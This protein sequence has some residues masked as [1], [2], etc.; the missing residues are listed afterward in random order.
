MYVIV[1][2]GLFVGSYDAN[3][4]AMCFQ[5][6]MIYF[7]TAVITVPITFRYFAVCR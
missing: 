2:S 5:I 1:L 6:L 3:Y 4:I 7:T